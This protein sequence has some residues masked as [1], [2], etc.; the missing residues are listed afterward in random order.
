MRSVVNTDKLNKE[1]EE[2]LQFPVDLLHGQMLRLSLKGKPFNTF[3]P[4]SD[5][6]IDM[7]W[8]KCKEID[9]GIQVR[10]KNPSQ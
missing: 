2:P 1:L 10:Y 9:Q 6:S 7:L 8:N 3:K 5:E 4:A